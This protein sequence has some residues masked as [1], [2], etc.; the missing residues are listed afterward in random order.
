MKTTYLD[1]SAIVKRY[2]QEPGSDVMSSLYS[3]AWSG[4]LRIAFSLWNFGEVLGVFDRYYRRGWL[5]KEGYE[6]AR[7]E[8]LYE[9]LRMLRLKL[10]KVVPLRVP[11][12]AAAWGLVEKH[13]IYQADAL[14]VASAKEVKADEFYTADQVLCRVAKLESLNTVCLG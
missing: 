8:F 13:H 2:I 10:L 7:V 14:Q 1:T 9:T 5:T 4:D 6:I 11:V 3:R 12:V